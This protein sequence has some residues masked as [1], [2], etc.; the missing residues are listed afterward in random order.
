MLIAE[1][2]NSLTKT[3]FSGGFKPPKPYLNTT[4]LIYGVKYVW[5]FFYLQTLFFTNLLEFRIN[6]NYNEE[7]NRYYCTGGTAR[8]LTHNVSQTTGGPVTIGK[9]LW[10]K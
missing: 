8:G 2:C 6:K 5:L 7:N 10:Y 3:I 4:L 9:N 1:Y